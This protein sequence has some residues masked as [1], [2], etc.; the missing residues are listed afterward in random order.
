MTF[1]MLPKV[2]MFE[3]ITDNPVPFLWQV[4]KEDFEIYRKSLEFME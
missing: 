2:M 4:E 1:Y 3:E